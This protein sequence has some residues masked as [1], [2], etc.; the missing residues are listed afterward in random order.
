MRVPMALA[1]TRRGTVVRP[2]L[3]LAATLALVLVAIAPQP[4][5][6][7]SVIRSYSIR[8]QTTTHGSIALI[9]NTM[10]TCP[11]ADAACASARDGTATGGPANNNNY[12]MVVVDV[13]G[14]AT[15]TDSSRATLSL[16]ASAA[17]EFAGL[18]WQATSTSAARNTVSL[19]LPGAGYATVTAS[20]VDTTGPDIYAAFADVTAQVDALAGPNGDYTVADMQV[21]TGANRHGGWSL[22]VV[23]EDGA[24]PL[25]NLTV[26]DG[27][28]VVNSTAPTSITTAVS[29]FVT[30]STG[31]VNAELGLVAGEGDRGMTGDQFQIDGANISD[32][33]NPSTN[34][35]NST[36]SD[37]GSTVT[38]KLPN[39]VNQLGWDVDRLDATGLVANGATSANLTFTTGGETYYPQAL[40]FAVDVFEPSLEA[41]KA[42]T[43]VNGGNLRPGDQI[44][45]TIDVTNV[46]NDPATEV[47]L[48]DLIPDHTS[49]VAGSLEIL[50]GANAGP[51]T[52]A[53]GDDQG[54]LASGT[55]TVRLGTGAD[56]AT[57]GTL[58]LGASTSIRFRVSVDAGTSGS[59]A[60]TNQA[61][62][63][64]RGQTLGASFSAL[65]DSDSGTA[66]DQPDD[67]TTAPPGAPVAADDS[68]TVSEGG[69][70][71][72]D[73]L[74]N[75]T[76]PDGN[77]D[78]ASVTVTAGPANGSVSVD[79]STG[80]ITYTPDPGFTG[81][82]TFTYQVCDT[83]ALCDTATV[84]VMVNAVADPPVA[85]ADNATVP[86]DG[87]TS[88]DVLAN[89]TD[90]DGDIDPTTV[91]V[92]VPPAHGTV[93]VD[94][95]TGAI[96]YT[97]DPDFDGP[98]TFTYQVCDATALC[99][100]AVVNVTVTPV[101][102]PPL[103]LADSATVSAGGSVAIDVLAN[104]TDPD[105][106]LDPTTVSVTTSPAHGTVLVDPVT[107][108][109]TYT[110]DA[111]YSGPD[112]F[113][114]QVCD[115]LGAC[116]SASV[117]VSVVAI[118]STAVT[119]PGAPPAASPP[120]RTVL[121]ALA[122]IVLMAAIVLAAGLRRGR[123]RPS[124]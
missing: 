102:D 59:T 34:V 92:T 112:A 62:L 39:Y 9:G 121:L 42:G 43:D 35:F 123:R 48:S 3:A 64:Y 70:V 83:T 55:V 13:D 65:S 20:S 116:A 38:A 37:L 23:Y 95:A 2:V 118:P 114:Y 45:Y 5:D 99:A 74:G 11:D 54:E 28:A 14:D 115:A 15:T 61:T 24:Q 31:T 32:A 89:D 97:P 66:G 7:S 120:D 49:Y 58:G 117:S 72:I 100:T 111:G 46:G 71:D 41:T 17:V 44:E 88:I 75:D 12:S 107:G 33:A 57:G 94:A 47:V 68:A 6:A 10:V 86:E 52:D 85:V 109:I 18:Y 60:I 53:S 82:D 16:P 113:T 101:A 96:G 51:L 78:P 84:S 91:S 8:F 56:A 19:A 26:F 77:L 108:A 63:A 36:V 87:T 29:G 73:V 69:S 80:E 4:V 105:G 122:G 104:D 119:P 98:D 79:P 27:F 103:A 76:D 21:T 22:V 93:L 40:T 106:D 110:P 25:R 1:S 81:P 67:I 30:P 50:S 90:P 124:D